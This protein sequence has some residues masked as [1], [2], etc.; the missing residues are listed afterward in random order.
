M[1]AI[2]A[3]EGPKTTEA[4]LEDEDVQKKAQSEAGMT[5]VSMADGDAAAANAKLAPFW[6]GLGQGKRPRI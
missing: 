3:E 5:L 1:R 6:E 2:V 4:F